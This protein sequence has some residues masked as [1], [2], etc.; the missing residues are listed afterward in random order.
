MRKYKRNG[1]RKHR[2]SYPP[3]RLT[4]NCS[5]NTMKLRLSGNFVFPTI[6]V[7]RGS[8]VKMD[9]LDRLEIILSGLGL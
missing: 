5:G 1:S 7:L 3:K 4:M 9:F 8:V 2:S 6:C